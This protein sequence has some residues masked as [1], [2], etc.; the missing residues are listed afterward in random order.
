MAKRPHTACRQPRRHRP[1]LWPP[2]LRGPH[3]A[4][5]SRRGPG[6]AWLCA[7][8]SEKGTRS[9]TGRART[10]TARRNTTRRTIT[11]V[12]R[13]RPTMEGKTARGASS[14]AKPA[15]RIESIAGARTGTGNAVS[16]A[17]KATARRGTAR[18]E[19]G[20]KKSSTLRGATSP[21][22]AARG[23]RPTQRASWSRARH[24][25]AHGSAPTSHGGPRRGGGSCRRERKGARSRCARACAGAPSCSSFPPPPRRARNIRALQGGEG[26]GRGGGRRA[27]PPPPPPRVRR[28]THPSPC[29]SRC[30][31][32]APTPRH[33]PPWWR[34]RVAVACVPCRA[35][36]AEWGPTAVR[37]RF[38]A[39]ARD[40]SAPGELCAK[41]PHPR[42]EAHAPRWK[43]HRIRKRRNPPRAL[44]RRPL[45]HPDGGF[46]LASFRLVFKKKKKAGEASIDAL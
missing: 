3:Q 35:V 5:R 40:R 7:S 14:P 43:T 1:R 16:D 20:S 45:A 18:R 25:R 8:N 10:H 31:T 29:L 22:R 21:S 6:A 36:R 9:R 2:R 4:N 44:H 30:R 24:T 27:P 34:A 19:K 38:R 26:W 23:A 13:G 28:A 39:P 42:R 15:A 32:R 17:A 37:A 46:G 12:W 41:S 33:R 11:P